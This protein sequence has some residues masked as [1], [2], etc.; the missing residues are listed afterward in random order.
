VMSR[1]AHCVYALG[2]IT[3]TNTPQLVNRHDVRHT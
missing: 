3:I 1:S 2:S